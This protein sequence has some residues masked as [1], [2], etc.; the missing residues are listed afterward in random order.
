MTG[1][2]SIPYSANR[3]TIYY[4]PP[5][6]QAVKKRQTSLPTPPCRPRQ[7]RPHSIHITRL[8]AG[9]VP[10]DLRPPSSPAQPKKPSRA[11]SQLNKLASRES[12][13]RVLGS[14]FSPFSSPN[15]TSSSAASST[16]PPSPQVSRSQSVRTNSGDRRS[17]FSRRAQSSSGLEAGSE[18]GM[19]NGPGPSNRDSLGIEN[20]PFGNDQT[21]SD[22]SL[23]NV[24]TLPNAGVGENEKPVASGNGLSVSI[25]FAEPIVYLSGLDHDG[26]TRDSP[27]S[28]GI[29]RGK[30]RL[31]VTKSAKIKAITLTFKGRARTEWPE[32][33]PPAKT[34]TFQEESLRTQVLPFFNALYEGSE[35]GYGTQCNYYLRDKSGTTTI[36]ALDSSSSG[37][38]T[39][40]GAR[41]RANTLMSSKE[42]KRLSLHNNQSRSFQKGDSPNGPTPQQ[43]GYK[44][45]H[46]GV[47]EYN[48]EIPIDNNC[49]ETTKLP[50]ATITWQVETLVERAGA[51]RA[52]LF[53]VKEVPVIRTPTI[54]SLE[55]VEPISISRNWDN[56]LHYDIMISGKS[57]PIGS[58]IPIAFKLTPLAKVQVHKIRIYITESIDYTTS[59]RT[60]TRK[61]KSLKKI[62]L[63]EK[64]AG[65]PLAKEYKSSEVRVLRGGE[66]SVE[67]RALARAAAQKERERVAVQFGRD[68]EPLPEQSENI[69]GDID[70]GLDHFAG[71]TE[72][73]MSV[74]LPTC[75]MMEKE[76]SK[77]INHDCSWKNVRVHHWFKITMRISRSD[78]DDPEG[79]K[80]RQF[81]IS[82]DSPFTILS[83]HASQPQMALP[84]YCDLG[85]QNVR[86]QRQR[87]CGC[88]NAA[89]TENPSITS[90]SRASSLD[91]LRQTFGSS[92]IARPET[93]QPLTRPPQA[94]LA[95]NTAVQRPMHMIRNPSFA[96]PDYEAEEAPPP[97]PTPTPPPM[98][99]H[100]VGTPSV[101][102]LADYFSRLADYEEEDH[103]DDED[104]ERASIRGRV[105]V[106]HPNTP[107]G[108]IARSMDINRDFMFNSAALNSR[109]GR[110]GNAAGSGSRDPSPTN[111]GIDEVEDLGRGVSG[112]SGKI[113]TPQGWM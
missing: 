10:F 66:L 1:Q 65:K 4:H 110:G 82:I 105:N 20:R 88:P 60:V 63:L 85:G 46:P 54:E 95:I 96:A 13:K 71:S 48:F 106:V 39:L 64:L 44:T 73:E 6:L 51:F 62:L 61:D 74:Q 59:D 21:D 107:G 98:Y 41:S 56:Q 80:R 53:G 11:K 84:A 67:D 32:G 79:K 76:K 83:C 70:L 58:R 23:R 33:V 102:G 28:I 45:F 77:R 35:V 18:A 72:L 42:S 30:V 87:V 38:S 99:D 92:A 108:R 89:N 97:M 31:N 2:I 40:L 100:V 57:F 16:R 24:K 17:I 22:L 15:S 78:P 37:I 101:D 25:P 3:G 103:T 7:R 55:L 68:P 5:N 75:E 14:V 19:M 8:P 43:R 81:E 49:P 52:N 69:L 27:N 50:S 90:A 86:S 12:A 93:A 26:T 29:L 112:I 94:H 111:R 113:E 34:E 36:T 109:I 47:Y 104:V 9:V 91:N